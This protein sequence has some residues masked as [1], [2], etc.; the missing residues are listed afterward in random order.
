MPP[1]SV[2]QGSPLVRDP[3]TAPEGAGEAKT[4]RWPAAPNLWALTEDTKGSARGWEAVTIFALVVA[5][6]VLTSGGVRAM[7]DVPPPS[8]IE[9]A[10]FRGRA[11]GTEGGRCGAHEEAR[12]V[13]RGTDPSD[14]R[15]CD[16]A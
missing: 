5:A 14:T 4:Q 12:I 3:A 15:L 1:P 16:W 13:H 10:P 7:S 8:P 9:P 2:T 6:L 11:G